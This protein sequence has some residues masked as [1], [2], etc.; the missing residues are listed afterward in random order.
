MKS[1]LLIYLKRHGETQTA[2]ALRTGWRQATISGWCNGVVPSIQWALEI[3]QATD[4]EVTVND[5][6]SF[7]AE[8]NKAFLQDNTPE[9][10]VQAATGC[11]AQP[12]SGGAR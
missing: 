5:W 1:P 11:K 10:N 3:Q 6:A 8:T 7:A 4:G 2:F 12:V 9:R